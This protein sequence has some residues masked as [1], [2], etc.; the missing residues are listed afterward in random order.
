MDGLES[1]TGLEDRLKYRIST[2]GQMR[3]Q[4]IINE[5]GLYSL[6]LSSKLP[7]VKHVDNEDKRGSQIATSGQ[8]RL[9]TVINESGLYSLTFGSKLPSAKH[10]DKEGKRTEIVNIS[11]LS[12]NATAFYR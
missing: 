2:A 1:H 8:R 6:I 12:Q 5:S 4:T 9:M 10:V 11:Q 3:E 7:S